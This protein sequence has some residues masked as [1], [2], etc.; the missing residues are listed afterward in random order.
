[1]VQ[2]F[3]S[4]TLTRWC[5]MHLGVRVHDREV[6]AKWSNLQPGPI[7]K[8]KPLLKL[9]VMQFARQSIN[10]PRVQTTQISL[11]TSKQ[12]VL[13]AYSP[14]LIFSFVIV[15]FD[16]GVNKSAEFA[17]G[18]RMLWT[19]CMTVGACTQLEGVKVPLFSV[20]ETC[21]MPQMGQTNRYDEYLISVQYEY[22]TW[23]L[24]V[25]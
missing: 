17:M 7:A 14:V 16:C 12:L 23:F 21:S 24:A 25:W 4:L 19:T 15:F 6:K 8:W 1:M 13:I 11:K 18:M 22:I 20:K 2:P 3:L 5:K 10:D 9:W